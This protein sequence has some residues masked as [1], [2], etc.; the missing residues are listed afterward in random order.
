MI[1]YQSSA[2]KNSYPYGYTYLTIS[3]CSNAGIINGNNYTG[4][5]VGYA[6]KLSQI[7]SSTNTADITGGNYVGGYIGYGVGTA[8]R[9]ATNNN[10][11]T[12]G[13]YVGGIAG[14]CGNLTDCTN[15]GIINS[16]AVVVENSESA[17]YVGGI[18]GY[19]TLINSCVNNADI[20]IETGG[21][22][23]GGIT[24]Y[25]Y[26]SNNTT[27]EGNT[28]NGEVSGR[29]Y[30]GGIVGNI[31]CAASANGTATF[32]NNENTKN[33]S[34][35]GN[36]IGGL[37]GYQSSAYKSSYPYGYT[38]LTISNCRNSGN[39]AGNNYV[40]GILAYGLYCTATDSVWASNSNI[41][42]VT[43]SNSGML[44]GYIG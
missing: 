40:G 34:G 28:N 21:K 39:I 3:S 1:G 17:A 27:C 33:V 14:Y 5:I 32:T 2:Y 23:V 29:D 8:I 9:I 43:G 4:G 35:N 26:L 12:G 36:Y 7:T 38:Y 15:N 16:T 19:A 13:A 42:T 20:I 31:Y 18:S 30:V 11:I 6:D 44:Y 25:L 41:G 37:I 22:Y 10:I 24:G